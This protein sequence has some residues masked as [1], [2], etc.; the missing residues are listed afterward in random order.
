MIKK[1]IFKNAIIAAFFTAQSFAQTTIT[2]W[3]FNGVSATTIPGDTTS[4]TP[5]VGSGSAELIGGT[6]ATFAA[7]NITAGTLETETV[8]TTPNYAWNTSNYA[9]LTTENKLRGVQF[10]VSTANYSGISFRFEQRHSNSC[11]NTFIAQYTTNRLAATPLWVDAQTFTFIPAATGT[12]DT[13][14]NGRIVDLSTVTALN[15]N[16]NA[17]FRIVSAFD[18]IT[19]DYLASNSTRSY[20]STGTARFEMVTVSAQNQLSNDK[21]ATVNSDFKIYPNPSNKGI[22]YFN[23]SQDIVVFDILGKQIY[24]DNN[25]KSFDTKNLQNGIYIIKTKSGITRKLVVN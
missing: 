23:S 19:S 16:A 1:Y 21:F 14:F 2:Q 25:T 20:L 12:G 3:N 7:G 17:A 13:W 10:N 4:P 24:T 6:T 22:V 18:P 9:A 8:T 15:N 11:N 5:S